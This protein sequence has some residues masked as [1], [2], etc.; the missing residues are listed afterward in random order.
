MNDIKNLKVAIYDSWTS[1]PPA[2]DEYLY[3][4]D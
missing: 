4:I 1:D 3:Y 2:G